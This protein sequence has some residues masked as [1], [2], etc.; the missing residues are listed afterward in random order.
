MVQGVGVG[1]ITIE[2]RETK[3]TQCSLGPCLN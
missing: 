3:E 2:T 1:L